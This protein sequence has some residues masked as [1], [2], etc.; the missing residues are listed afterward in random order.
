LKADH[1]APSCPNFE[2][3]AYP[4][5]L[6]TDYYGNLPIEFKLTWFTPQMLEEKLARRR[7]LVEQNRLRKE[8]EAELI[9]A[10]VKGQSNS[11]DVLVNDEKMTASQKDEILREY[12]KDLL[13]IEANHSEGKMELD[14][15]NLMLLSTNT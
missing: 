1:P 14:K 3:R 11:L 12:E 10:K 9:A 2:A 4:Q 8:A 6:S 13:R 5:F 15:K 7:E